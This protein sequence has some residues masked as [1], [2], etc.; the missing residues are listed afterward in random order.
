MGNDKL[1]DV[2]G[3][4]KENFLERFEDNEENNDLDI[5]EWEWVSDIWLQNLIT[6]SETYK[7]ILNENNEWYNQE[8]LKLFFCAK[9]Y[10]KIVKNWQ[11]DIKQK[12]IEEEMLLQK[13]VSKIW[14]LSNHFEKDK[15]SVKTEDRPI[16]WRMNIEFHMWK[17]CILAPWCLPNLNKLIKLWIINENNI[18]INLWNWVNLQESIS[19][20]KT[21]WTLW[22]YISWK[23]EE[24]DKLEKISIK[25]WNDCSFPHWA[26]F[27]PWERNDIKI[28]CWNWVF[29]GINTLIWSWTVIWNN[30]TIWWGT[31]LWNNVTL[32]DNLIIWQ[33]STVESNIILPDNCLVPNFSKITKW[34]E[35]IEYSDYEKNPNAL[36]WKRNYLIKLSTEYSEKSEQLGFINS[37]YNF[38]DRFNEHN[39]VPENKIFAAIDTI[40]NFLKEKIW[41]ESVQ[42]FEHNTNLEELKK[43]IWEKNISKEIIDKLNFWLDWK[44]RVVLKAYPKNIKEFL[45]E[46]MPIIFNEIIESQKKWT[47]LQEKNQILSRINNLVNRPNV[48]QKDIEHKFFWD[49]YITWKFNY[50]WDCIFVDLKSRWDELGVSEWINLE[51]VVFLR[52]TI[53]W[54]WDKLILNSN[55]YDLVAHWWVLYR[56]S[57]IWE[58]WKR[59]VLN[60]TI[61]TNSTILWDATINGACIKD[62]KISSEVSIAG[63]TWKDLVIIKSPDIWK[64]VCINAWTEVYWKKIE[65][66][67]KLWK[68]LIVTKLWISAKR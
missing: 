64:W 57:N 6:A 29:F 45:L 44:S 65:E 10:L 28:I 34:F 38:V 16:L 60:G 55:V 23:F 4:W 43:K 15:Y 27:Y 47:L 40:F 30:T 48:E 14:V 42:I 26:S 17:N 22:S 20:L 21:N 19:F 12:H 33:S 7:N 62:S 8:L 18:D 13:F 49:C 50:F 9:S 52:W 68:K 67:E 32:W 41:F 58:I 11:I 53:H 61:V 31:Q 66:W 36:V 25:T 51:N 1:I 46:E 39:V 56:N 35:I 3:M 24:N 2:W 54:W 5:Y 63:W 59:S 37:H